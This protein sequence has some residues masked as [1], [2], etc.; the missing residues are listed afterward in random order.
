MLVADYLK[1]SDEGK[2]ALIVVPTHSEGQKL[3]AELRE[4]LKERGAVGRDRAFK[5]RKST[6]WTEAEKGDVRNYAP[7][8]VIDFNE[9]IAGER[10]RMNGTRITQGGFKKGESVSVVG[11]EGESVKVMR[12]DGSHATLALNQ[13]ERF[14][15]SRVRDIAIARGDRLRI[16]K[17]GEARVEG[18]PKG[19]KVNNGDIFS[20]E[21]FTKD[22]DIRLEN[23]KLLPKDWGHF[24]HGYVDTNYSSQG[25]TTD[26]VFISVGDE[27]IPATDRKGW[28]VAASR[29]REQARIYVDSKEDV[30]NAIAKSGER[31]SAVELTGTRV[32]EGWRERFQRSFENSRVVNFVRQRATAIRDY[33]REREGL[34]YA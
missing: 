28:Y 30:R 21:G 14:Q 6:G 7:G 24:N 25:K 22:G 17:N 33:W 19:T 1:A 9:A 34:G 10:K 13:A 31:L 15:V 2:S 18:Q 23:G 5:A 12:R 32:Q 16:T 20:V 26:R 27:S 11:T 4:S 8:M 3:T 29:G